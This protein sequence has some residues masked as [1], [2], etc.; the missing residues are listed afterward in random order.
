M[1]KR[2]R[3]IV[4]LGAIFVVM[5]VIFIVLGFVLSGADILAWFGSKWAMW[6]YAF[7]CIYVLVIIYLIVSERIRSL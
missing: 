2:N 6:L 1:N 5:A 7:A 4:I 3:I